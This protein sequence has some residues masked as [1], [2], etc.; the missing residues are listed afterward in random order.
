MDRRE[1]RE[2][3]IN[4]EETLN[5]KYN[6][7]ELDI[8][9]TLSYLQYR[10]FDALKGYFHGYTVYQSEGSYKLHLET[11]SLRGNLPFDIK[12]SMAIS[13]TMHSLPLQVDPLQKL[14]LDNVTKE[15][16]VDERM[17]MQGHF[18]LSEETSLVPV[19]PENNGYILI[20]GKMSIRECKFKLTRKLS[21]L[22]PRLVVLSDDV[23][24]YLDSH[25]SYGEVVGLFQSLLQSCCRTLPVSSMSLIPDTTVSALLFLSPSFSVPTLPRRVEPT[26]I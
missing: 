21:T 17:S 10:Y 6:L 4:V 8:N 24:S 2:S 14:Y 11:L 1:L 26:T 23:S 13:G 25:Y 20:G 15:V 18:C 7:I 5:S 16:W 3:E 19:V 9:H 22:I 12:A